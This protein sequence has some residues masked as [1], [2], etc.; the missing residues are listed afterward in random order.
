M[1]RISL[2]E[3]HKQKLAEYGLQGISIDACECRR[4]EPGEMIYREF[5]NISWIGLVMEGY[6]KVCRT[7]ENGKTLILCYYI[8]NGVIGD[9]ELMSG[10]TTALASLTA[11]SYFECV[12]VRFQACLSEMKT[13]LDFLNKLAT[14][15]AGKLVETSGNFISA[16][17]CS[18]EQRLCSY[19]L[20]TSYC[21]VFRDILTDVSCSIG[22][23]YRHVTRLL[24]QLCD[25]GIL[26]KRAT[27]YYIAKRDLL[28][29][30]AQY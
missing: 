29:R 26:E 17:L 8:T 16:A 14:G 24:K 4:Y 5:E 19:I 6:S 25:E 20:Q 2:T 13:N 12:T 21:D 10:K 23:S 3:M 27:G 7:A 1:K 11:I 22:L 9:I 18:G 30:R 28:L 15:L